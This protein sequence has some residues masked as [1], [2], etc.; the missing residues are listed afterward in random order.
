MRTL[1]LLKHFLKIVFL[2]HW[3]LVSCHSFNEPLSPKITDNY[4]ST[5]DFQEADNLRYQQDYD[6]AA[7]A[8]QTL[9]DTE[10][11]N[12]LDSIYGL[13]QVAYCKLILNKTEGIKE[14]LALIDDLLNSNANAP[15]ILLTTHLFNQ[16]RYHFLQ[17]EPEQAIHYTHQA[18]RNFYQVYPPGHLKVAQGLTLLALIHDYEGN[19]TDSIHHYALLANDHFLNHSEISD[20]D[21]E[22]DFVH[23]L[24]CL[25]DRAHERGEY[26]C[27]AALQ[28]LEELSMDN[29]W[30]EAR[31]WHLLGKM[32]KKQGD[33]IVGEDATSLEQRRMQTNE[34]ANS[35]FQKAITI[36]KSQEDTALMVFYRDWIINVSRFSD[37]TRFFQ[38][39][40]VLQNEFSHD[41]AWSAHRDLLLGYYYYGID[42]GKTVKY[43][44]DFLNAKQKDSH[45][46]YR[47]FAEAYYVLRVA[48]NTKDAFL[49][50][51]NYAKQSLALYGCLD[52]TVDLHDDDAVQNIDSVKRYCLATSGFFA[53][54]MFKKYKKTKDFKDL[55]IA[56]T[57]FEFVEKHSF[58]SLLNTD[59]DA[60]LTFQFEV[61]IDIF[62]Y[63]IEAAFG[64]WQVTGDEYW[65][66]KGFSYIEY[67]KSHFLYRSMS[68]NSNPLVREKTLLDSIRI[69]QGQLNQ[70]F[71][72]LQ[73]E[74]NANT[75]S[76]KNNPIVGKL[77]QL[78]NRRSRKV[79]AIKENKQQSQIS[80]KTIQEKLERNQALVNYY[81]CNNHL[82]GI[83]ID[84]DTVFSF[85]L[86]E[87]GNLKQAVKNFR[88]SVEEETKL[89]QKSIV[90][91][92]NSAEMLY[93][94]LIQPFGNRLKSIEELIII[95]DELLSSIAFEAFLSKE[96]NPMKVKFKE[97]PYLLK[98]IQI[99]Y[100]PSWKVFEINKNKK[101]LH[102]KSVGLW[103]TPELSKRNGL[104]VI[105]ESIANYKHISYQIFNQNKG[106][107][108]S[109]FNNHQHFDILHLLLH[110]N[111]NR[112][113]RYDNL[114]RFGSD[115][116]DTAYGFELY[117]QKFTNNL[118][119]LSSCE[120]AAGTPQVGE[121][122]F[123]LAR[124]FMNAGIPEVL[125]AQ[126]LIPQT[127]T[128]SLLQK[129]YSHLQ[130]GNNA[131]TA[132]HQAKMD[133]IQE[134]SKDRYAFPRFWAG[135][136]VL[137]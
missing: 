40:E 50:S 81:N 69:L 110:A 20:Y 54:D 128:A 42:W 63:G 4:K 113:N 18:L 47:H 65:L 89:D 125:A 58:Q 16:G 88:F 72:K 126:F 22:M 116:E 55:Q 103:T 8:Y 19:V 86:E 76:L 21:W 25:L 33:A 64:A 97:L 36:G 67:L 115:Q 84:S 52:R 130:D 123:S 27:R 57:Y 11:L 28:K 107:K 133:Y 51:A 49:P 106:G 73:E 94:L 90:E 96:I 83:Y 41:E 62:S 92:L 6:Q 44:G 85:K 3:L 46:N 95:P 114:I 124:C 31:L 91:Y 134:T 48:Y 74:E 100:S 120:S 66:E 111:S 23:G 79:D 122:T 10:N 56:N 17:L 35:I 39:M 75:L 68:K 70:T 136:V 131:A 80:I 117:R 102:Y 82:F 118:L 43:Y 37:S 9:L 127:T 53:V 1:E 32:I 5:I 71:F 109:F 135:M 30:L 60:F 77:K 108:T 12:P 105:E 101:S 137:N 15:Q 34:E 59:E 7:I 119:I 98:D 61:G 38:A 121:G 104:Q 29:K 14:Q 129:F 13:N 78:E 99:V 93:D 45:I 132:L 112:T 24:T 87:N 26:H 2:S